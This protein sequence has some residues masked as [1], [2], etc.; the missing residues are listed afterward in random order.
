MSAEPDNLVL[1]LL[2]DMRTEMASMRSEMADM[3]GDLTSKINSLRADVAADF[4]AFEARQAK[5]HKHTREQIEG[6]RREVGQYHASIAGHG[7]L[8]SEHDDRLRRLER[9]LG[10]PALETH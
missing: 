1:Q 9:H 3:R 4:I 5:E 8:I 7:A 6:L 10:L 2:R